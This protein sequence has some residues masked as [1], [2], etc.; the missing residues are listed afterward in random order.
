MWTLSVNGSSLS[1]IVLWE[2]Y[3][4]W[5]NSCLGGLSKLIW[6]IFHLCCYTYWELCTSSVLFNFSDCVFAVTQLYFAMLSDDIGSMR[7]KDL[8]KWHDFLSFLFFCFF[9]SWDQKKIH[10]STAI[11]FIWRRFLVDFFNHLTWSS[12]VVIHW[13]SGLQFQLKRLIEKFSLKLYLWE[14][15]GEI[16]CT[17]FSKSV[18]IWH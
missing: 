18:N 7:I 5:T 10:C 16:V 11:L 13:H 3:R 8:F 14:R 15:C 1:C 2:G 12:S 17:F 4:L 6:A 9:S